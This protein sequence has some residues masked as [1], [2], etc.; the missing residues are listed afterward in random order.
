[1]Y[2]FP[3]CLI[4]CMMWLLLLLNELPQHIVADKNHFFTLMDSVGPDRQDS[5]TLLHSV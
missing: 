2:L 5:L 3:D 1:M 4:N